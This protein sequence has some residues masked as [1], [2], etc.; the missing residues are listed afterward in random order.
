MGKRLAVVAL[1]ALGAFMA[2]PIEM[3]AAAL[4]NGQQVP[5]TALAQ[6]PFTA[7]V[8]FASGQVIEVKVPANTLFPP[9]QNV[10]IQECQALPGGLP[11]TDITKCDGLTAYPSTNLPHADGSFD[12]KDYSLYSLP[13][14]F[15]LGEPP[16]SATHCD[17]STPCVLYMGLNAQDFTQPHI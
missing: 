12:I 5:G 17:L 8:P 1:V 7:G 4:V 2:M 3:A 14:A 16:S 15:S 6:T 11:P 9:T 13:N 10:Q